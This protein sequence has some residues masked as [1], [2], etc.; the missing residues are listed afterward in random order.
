MPQGR[1]QPAEI[2]RIASVMQ[3][4]RAEGAV[5]A[6]EQLGL[7]DW[8]RITSANACRVLPKLAALLPDVARG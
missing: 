8:Q 1:N 3:Q 2:P 5:A 7:A 4:V 6:A